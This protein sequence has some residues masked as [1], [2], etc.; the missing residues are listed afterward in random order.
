MNL[1]STKSHLSYQVGRWDHYQWCPESIT[2]GLNLANASA[3]KTFLFND[4]H[5]NK[6]DIIWVFFSIG[7]CLEAKWQTSA[8]QCLK[9]KWHKAILQRH[10]IYRPW[11]SSWHHQYWYS[12]VCAYSGQW[13]HSTE[14][15]QSLTLSFFHLDSKT[16]KPVLS[17]FFLIEFSGFLS[18][19]IL[20]TEKVTLTCWQ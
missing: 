7:L 2:D 10:L 8:R 13:H 1:F 5:T 18:D 19:F 16:M 12:T 6:G 9:D 14:S 17:F 11:L 3:W 4:V 15:F 20:S